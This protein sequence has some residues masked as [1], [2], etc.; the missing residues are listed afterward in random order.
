MH[1]R[2]IVALSLRPV[3]ATAASFRAVQQTGISCTVV[4]VCMCLHAASMCVAVAARCCQQACLPQRQVMR[5]AGC[6]STRRLTACLC[7]LPCGLSPSTATRLRAARM[8]SAHA[9]LHLTCTTSFSPVLR[10]VRK[11]PVVSR[12]VEWGAAEMA[13]QGMHGAHWCR[14]LHVL[15]C[16]RGTCN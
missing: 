1:G 6:S 4:L 5:C 9:S 14:R 3:G 13:D 12:Q 15:Q 2:S 16:G 8:A 10:E 7:W 11:L